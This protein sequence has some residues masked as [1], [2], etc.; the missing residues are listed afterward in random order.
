MYIILHEKNVF[1]MFEAINNYI[2]LYVCLFL[3]LHYV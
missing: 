1:I 3:K 2:Y